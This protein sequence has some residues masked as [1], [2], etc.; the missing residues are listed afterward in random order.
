VKTGKAE[1]NYLSVSLLDCGDLCMLLS[2]TSKP[3]TSQSC[4]SCN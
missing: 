2:L 1:H 3:G 4:I